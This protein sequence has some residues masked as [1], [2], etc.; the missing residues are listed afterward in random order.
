MFASRDHGV[1][2]APVWGSVGNGRA[3]FNSMGFA[4]QMMMLSVTLLCLNEASVSNIGQ[5][6]EQFPYD[7]W[8]KLPFLFHPVRDGMEMESK[9]FR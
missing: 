7:C 3:Y 6:G 2:L 4:R 1:A 8:I 5:A 9:C